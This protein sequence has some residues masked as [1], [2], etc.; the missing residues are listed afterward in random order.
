VDASRQAEDAFLN[1]A[2]FAQQVA[3]IRG[4][5]LQK[6][7]DKIQLRSDPD[8]MVLFRTRVHPY[9]LQ[10]CATAACH[11]APTAKFR[12]LRPGGTSVSDELLYT[13]FYI[14][15]NYTRPVAGTVEKMINRDDP[16]K[17]LLL[18]Y[19]LPKSVAAI[20]HPGKIQLHHFPS[21]DA[22]DFQLMAR[23]IRSLTFPTPVYNLPPAKPAAARARAGAGGTTAP[24]R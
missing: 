2:N 14:L 23:W 15:S 9:V 19:G 10:N 1:P 4:S 6:Y 7:I 11:A 21:E 20:P 18:Q 13:N 5:G 3:A 24:G 22:P 17:S 16:R 8:D 12:L